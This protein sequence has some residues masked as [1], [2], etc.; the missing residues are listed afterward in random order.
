MAKASS[1]TAGRTADY[2]V[3]IDRCLKIVNTQTR[4]VGFLMREGE[5]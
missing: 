5:P 4:G 3:A 2:G 1:A